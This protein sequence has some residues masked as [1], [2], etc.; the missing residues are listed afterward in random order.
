VQTTKPSFAISLRLLAVA[1]NLQMVDGASGFWDTSDVRL[2]ETVAL[3]ME[4][5]KF[6][7]V[8]AAVFVV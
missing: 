7:T 4:G 5:T 8:G 3:L 2:A 6:I 1:A